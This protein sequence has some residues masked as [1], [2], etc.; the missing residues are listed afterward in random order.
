MPFRPWSQMFS[1]LTGTSLRPPRR[2]DSTLINQSVQDR[3][4][5]EGG[6]TGGNWKVLSYWKL[7]RKLLFPQSIV[8]LFSWNTLRNTCVSISEWAGEHGYFPLL[9]FLKNW[10]TSLVV[11]SLRICLP[12]QG[13]EAQ[14]LSREDPTCHGATKSEHHN[15][16]SP[17]TLQS[18][19]CNKR[20]HRSE[21]PIH[22]NWRSPRSQQLAKQWTQCNQKQV[23]K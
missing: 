19:L 20:S 3:T 13:T 21:K 9:S 15:S 23:N 5:E 11:H 12:M 14:S 6:K 10:G 1:K 2:C 17:C 22:H 4:R 8:R 18:M 7:T 16:W